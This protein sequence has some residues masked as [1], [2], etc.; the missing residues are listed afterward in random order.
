MTEKSKV[1]LVEEI[2]S[3]HQELE[4]IKLSLYGTEIKYK[5][6]YTIVDRIEGLDVRLYVQEEDGGLSNYIKIPLQDLLQ[7]LS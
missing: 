5:G 6:S 7:Y 1:A 3:R 2:L 4:D